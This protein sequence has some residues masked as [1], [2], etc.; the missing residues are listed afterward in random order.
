[1]NNRANCLI[2]THDRDALEAITPI[3]LSQGLGVQVV[4][5]A[6]AAEVEL[7]AQPYD[8]LIMDCEL[9]GADSVM[10]NAHDLGTFEKSIR[11]VAL[12]PE[13]ERLTTFRNTAAAFVIFKPLDNA[14]S[15]RALTL[16]M[17]TLNSDLRRA[18]RQ[19][20]DFPV[21]LNMNYRREVPAKAVNLSITGMCA[22]VREPILARKDIRI[23]FQL[24]LLYRHVDAKCD[25]TR[26]ESNG[27]VGLRFTDMRR[28]DR[29]AIRQYLDTFTGTGRF[30]GGSVGEL[31]YRSQLSR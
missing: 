11:I 21:F 4:G 6:M 22:K 15:L 18:K 16:A 2:A 9:R 20:V 19:P 13:S 14:G 8:G 3:L 5:S 23:R 27:E 1:M 31:E 12:L 25:I 17:R 28:E 30:S 24:P 7:N 29:D 26:A 10:R